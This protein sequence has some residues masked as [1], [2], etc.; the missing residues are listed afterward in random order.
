MASSH[1]PRHT[2][3]I[4]EA[5]TL[6]LKDEGFGLGSGPAERARKAAENLLEWISDSDNK[7][8]WEQFAGELVTSLKGC[9]QVGQVQKIQKR[10]ERMWERYH[11]LRSSQQFQTCWA[12]FLEVSIKCE[13]CPIFFQFVSDAIM[14]M[15]I[16]NEF[17][18]KEA[19]SNDE[20]S[21][22]YEEKNAVQYYCWVHAQGTEEEGRPIRTPTEEALFGRDE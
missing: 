17:P 15:L 1:G 18:V 9:F 16:N 3:M 2:E 4:R 13:S 11:K 21:L 19:R 5:L 20:V 14:E 8:L 22:D 6:I 12:S 10:R 7:E